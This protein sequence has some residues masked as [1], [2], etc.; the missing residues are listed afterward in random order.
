VTPSVADSVALFSNQHAFRGIAGTHTGIYSIALYLVR[1]A[2]L[3]NAYSGQAPG[4][5]FSDSV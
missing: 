4:D 3:L 5:G 2:L 1:E